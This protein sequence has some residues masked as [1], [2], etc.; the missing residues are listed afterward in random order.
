MALILCVVLYFGIITMLIQSS[1][2]H[3]LATMQKSC[4][5]MS[6][7]YRG[8]VG[9]STRYSSKSLQRTHAI[10]TRLNTIPHP[11]E[12]RYWFYNDCVSALEKALEEGD[13]DTGRL[14]S[15][16]C[17]IPELNQN[18]DVYR[19]GTLLE[20]VRE[21]TTMLSSRGKRCKVCVQQS[22]GQGVFCGTPLALSGVRRILNQMDWGE[23]EVAIGQL[24]RDEID[25]CDAYVII[26][27]QNITGHSVLPLIAEMVEEAGDD[28]KDIILIN[29]QLAD[30]MSSG[31]VMSVRGRQE[32]MDFVSEFI[33]AYHF[34][35]LYI[36]MGPYPIMGALRYVYGGL[37]EVYRRVDYKEENDGTPRERYD[38]L[39]TFETEPDSKQITEAFRKK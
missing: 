17:T 6:H 39:E 28:G 2:S 9:I 11:R 31:G 7:V 27:P 20:C 33:P 12:T 30:I 22:L 25:D 38:L 10:P 5:D 24:G 15:L 3:R 14:L 32:R 37:W 26:S 29:P 8:R 1:A 4:R 18:F 19:V 35:L 23:D 34:R 21:L 36:G 16:K 13:T